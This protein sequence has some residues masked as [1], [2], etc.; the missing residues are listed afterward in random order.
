MQKVVGSSPIIRSSRSPRNRG[1]F[2]R[3]W[4]R[5]ADLALSEYAGLPDGRKGGWEMKLDLQT[6]AL[7]A[8][9]AALW[10]AVFEGFNAF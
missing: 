5:L 1:F 9:A 4:W 2:V 10:V 8:I 3:K 6:L 7:V